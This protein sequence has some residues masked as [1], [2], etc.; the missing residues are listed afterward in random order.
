MLH[1]RSA[2]LLALLGPM[3]AAQGTD[4]PLSIERMR[5]RT[6]PGSTLTTQQTLSPG[7][8]YT[9][10]VVSYQSDGLRIHALLTVPNGIPP[11]GGWPAIVFNH[12]YIP[13]NLYRTTERYVAY[14]DAFARAG[15]VVLKPDYR[16]H[17]RSQGRPTG[18][19]Y[20]SPEYTT[21]VLNAVS[22][23][24]TLPS[25][26]RA[27]LGMWGHSMGGHITLRAMVVSPDIKAGVIWAGVVG[28]YELLFNAL[29]QWGR[30]DPNDSRAQLLAD[31]GRP[32]CNPA[33]YQAISPNASL[34]DL[35]GRPLQL[36]HATGDTHVPYSLSQA[37]ANGLKA[38]GQPV[39]FY[40]Y[41][42]DNHDLSRNLKTAL[43]RSV[44]FFKKNL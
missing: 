39:T 19:S 42:N 36:H 4:H 16:G 18:T 38:A 2:L 23:L 26:N 37:L 20:W 12:G 30:S 24:H 27:R 13:P 34:A 44:A 22:S 9:R 28:P 25:V 11:K 43:E 5:A 41:T 3:T 1:I 15:F 7:V 8:N 10:R 35:R 29:P 6:Y 40:T 21:D 17:G 31:L 32:E 14:V 33:A